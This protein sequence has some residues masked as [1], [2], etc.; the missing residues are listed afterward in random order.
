[1]TG[2]RP[3]IYWQLTWRYISPGLLAILTV[4]SVW[5]YVKEAPKYGAWQADLVRTYFYYHPYNPSK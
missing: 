5:G 4:A 3:G 1:M 2:Y